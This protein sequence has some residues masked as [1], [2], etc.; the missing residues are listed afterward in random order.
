MNSPRCIAAQNRCTTSVTIRSENLAI[1][2]LRSP[3]HDRRAPPQ[4][5]PPSSDRTARRSPRRLAL[6]LGFATTGAL[7]NHGGRTTQK[8]PRSAGCCDHREN[9]R[10][11]SLVHLRSADPS[12]LP[13]PR[14]PVVT[15][16]HGVVRAASRPPPQLRDQAA[17]S[18]T[19]PLR[20][21]SDEVFHPARSDSASWRTFSSTH[22]TTAALG[23]VQIQARRCR[24]T[25]SMNC[26]SGESLNVSV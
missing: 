22:S 9:P 13:H 8:V 5:T 7:L 2:R 20:R 23:R 10:Y 21:P 25:L 6:G 18:S 14:T 26:G 19:R 17:L 15:P 16:R 4:V 3:R 12:R 24:L 1:D 11:R